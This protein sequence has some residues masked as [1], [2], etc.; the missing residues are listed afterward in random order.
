V[1]GIYRLFSLLTLYIKCSVDRHFPSLRRKYPNFIQV[2][3]RKRRALGTH[4]GSLFSLGEAQGT[5]SNKMKSS[6]QAHDDRTLHSCPRRRQEQEGQNS[7]SSSSWRALDGP[8]QS[9]PSLPAV[10]CDAA[11]Q[12]E[13]LSRRKARMIQCIDA[14]LSLLEDYEIDLPAQDQ[15]DLRW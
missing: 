10:A 7:S 3:H 14:A 1:W 9:L 2:D 5:K 6:S 8:P 15:C 12:M 13:L 11:G 4:R